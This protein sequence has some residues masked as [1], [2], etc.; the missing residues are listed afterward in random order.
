MNKLTHMM[1]QH[2][3]IG[4]LI[5]ALRSITQYLR[6]L[7]YQY[8]HHVWYAAATSQIAAMC[9]LPIGLSLKR[10]GFEHVDF[11]SQANLCGRREATKFFS[12]NADLWIVRDAEQAAFCCWIFRYYMPAVAARGGW[13]E[14]PLKTVCLEGST[15]GTRY[16]GRGIAP[17]AWAL[18]AHD[19]QREGVHTIITKV[20][21][22]NTS[23]RR[24]VLKAGFHEA[25]ATEFFKLGAI[26]RLRVTPIGEVREQDRVMLYDLRNLLRPS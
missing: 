26:S 13:M 25:A 21:I 22:D 16:R 14:L 9:P 10:G 15:T 5:L 23:S 12:E 19:L 24:A 17:M 2:G 8:E 1:L 7:C 4:C 20:A 18:I 3:F 11:L 6:A